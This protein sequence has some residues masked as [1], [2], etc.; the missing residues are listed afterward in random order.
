MIIHTKQE[1]TDKKIVKVQKEKLKWVARESEVIFCISE[2]TKKDV[3]DYLK[4]D[5]DKV[6]VVYPGYEI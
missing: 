6:M 5:K 4:I 3:V 2:S 1:E